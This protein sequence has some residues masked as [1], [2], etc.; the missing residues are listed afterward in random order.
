VIRFEDVHKSLEGRPVLA[1]LTFEVRERETF[2]IMGP[3][4]TGKSVTLKHIVGVHRPDAGRVEVDGVD[5][6]AADREGLRRLRRRV[7]YLFQEGALL[8]WLSVLENVELPL[9]ELTD[10]APEEIRRRALEKLALVHLADAGDR[11]PSVLSG[12]MR[13]RVS[14]ARALVTE[15]RIMLYDEPNAGLDPGTAADINR[16]ILATRDRLGVTSVVVTHRLACAFTVGDRIAL[17]EGGRIVAEGPPPEFRSSSDARVQRFLG[18]GQ[19]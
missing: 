2:V 9:R 7:G 4:G 8:G 6:G 19:D 11:M 1:G 14:L 16:L 13:K 18:T 15:P 17:L 5:V 3:S 12:G 10:L